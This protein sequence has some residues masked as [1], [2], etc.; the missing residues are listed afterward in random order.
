MRNNEALNAAVEAGSTPNFMSNKTDIVEYYRDTYGKDWRKHY[1][2]DTIRAEG[3]PNT[4]KVRNTISRRVQGDRAD[5]PARQG[6]TRES[7]EKLGQQLPPTSRTPKSETI[8][9][10]VTGK[11][12]NGTRD[13]SISVTLSGSAAYDFVNNPSFDAIYDEYFDGDYDGEF[14]YD[15]SELAVAGVSIS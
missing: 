10:T 6:A 11:Q 2:S 12:E 1:T 3:L 15:S 8:T 13:R 7:F 9:V 4:A 5:K 14:D